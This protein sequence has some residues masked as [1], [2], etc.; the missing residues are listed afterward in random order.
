MNGCKPIYRDW[1]GGNDATIYE[2]TKA[3]FGYRQKQLKYILTEPVLI[4]NEYPRFK[5]IENGSLIQC[6]KSHLHII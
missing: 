5:N 4:M 6:V 1:G 3:T 2:Y